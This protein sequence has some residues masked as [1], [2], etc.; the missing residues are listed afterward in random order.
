MD[1]LLAAAILATAVSTCVIALRMR[2]LIS[3]IEEQ[4]RSLN[5]IEDV[6]LLSARRPHSAAETG[7]PKEQEAQRCLTDESS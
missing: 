2:P 1:F 6:L 4:T 7:D 5:R 3:A